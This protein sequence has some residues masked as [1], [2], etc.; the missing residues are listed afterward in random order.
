MTTRPDRFVRLRS[1][2]LRA[3]GDWSDPQTPGILRRRRAAIAGI[4]ALASALVL[5]VRA[6][7]VPLPALDALYVL[8][9]YAA[10]PIWGYTWTLFAP[11]SITW[12]SLAGIAFAI[13]LATFL[14]RRS[15]VRGLHARLC[16]LVV[17]HVVAPG[18][19]P[20]YVARLTAWVDWLAARRL[21]AALLEDVVRLEQTDALTA[22]VGDSALDEVAAGRLVRLTDLLA[23]L[24]SHAGAS[25]RERWRSLAIWHQ[26][27]MWI[28]RRAGT[29]PQ[30]PPRGSGQAGGAAALFTALAA[31]GRS[32]LDRLDEVDGVEGDVL[33]SGLRRDLQWLVEYAESGSGRPGFMRSVLER[34]D[35]LWALA[36]R[37]SLAERESHDES[38]SPLTARSPDGVIE[39]QGIL[40][41]SIGLHAASRVDDVHLAAAHLE[42]F[43][44][45]GFVARL[46]VAGREGGRVAR[47]LTAAA[48][49]RDHYR[50]AADI[51]ESRRAL[52]AGAPRVGR[53]AFDEA[54]GQERIRIDGLHDAA[55]LDFAAR[56]ST[57]TQ[58]PAVAPDASSAFPLRAS[59][60]QGGR[61]LRSRLQLRIRQRP[62]PLRMRV[63]PVL[64]GGLA[65]A[66]A[67][68]CVA[69][70]TLV[71][72][73]GWIDTARWSARSLS[74]PRLLENVRRGLDTAPFLDA[75]FH[76][77]DRQL[78]VSQQ[79]GVLHSY[80]PDTGL[81]STARPFGPTD[82][83]WPDVRLLASSTDERSG[84]LWGVTAGGGLVRRLNGHWE[85]IVGDT[86]FLGRQGTPVQQAD[87]SAVAASSDGK[88]L[89]AAAGAEGVGL[90][91]LT[92]RRWLSRDE[93]SGNDS[94]SAVTHAVWW[95][96]RFYVGGPDGV[97]EL[98]VGGPSTRLGAGPSTRLGAGP[99][100]TFRRVKGLDGAVVA[101]EATPADGLF[102]HETVPCQNGPSACVRLSRMTES[103]P[104]KCS[105]WPSN[106]P[107]GPA[108]MIP[109]CVCM[110]MF[111]M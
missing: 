30:I 4:A 3:I 79:G 25:A 91:D 92:R 17:V 48:P 5:L 102:V 67:V 95:R 62:L 87:L 47:A 33:S 70:A 43:E 83:A 36:E 82:L 84:A 80:D 88:W 86:T 2:L 59:A 6:D 103:M 93:I 11:Y 77:P 74:D 8:H 97:S 35:E 1:P 99:P 71:L 94:P 16:R 37:G 68:Y 28:D 42:A 78:V 104:F 7:L 65:A 20:R 101:L 66:A 73:F 111:Q 40:V 64:L 57:P 12:W 61:D 10:L 45:L 85:V 14:T 23:R 41:S 34:L 105:R 81:W 60:R 22:I 31:T 19:S 55:G 56:S 54:A 90:Q 110:Q 98:A 76:A 109:T 108:P 13:W 89:L 15:A 69:T 9:D 24:T 58:I 75:V 44:A 107:A 39:A 96:D 29:A 46:G 18:R 100:F 38:A 21:G 27:L 52:R 51:A 49:E 32:L 53:A 72:L 106:N 63:D 50:L 26:A